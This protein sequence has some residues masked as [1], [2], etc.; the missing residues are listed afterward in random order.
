MITDGTLFTK[1]AKVYMAKKPSMT[2]RPCRRRLAMPVQE[3]P[4]SPTRKPRKQNFRG[5]RAAGRIQNF[6]AQPLSGSAITDK[7]NQGVLEKFYWDHINIHKD[8]P[9][10]EYLSKQSGFPIGQV[11]EYLKLVSLR[12][13]QRVHRLGINKI[14]TALQL[15]SETGDPQAIKLYFQLVEDWSERLRVTN[16]D[17]P[18]QVIVVGGKEI[19]F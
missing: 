1:S 12:A 10:L 9:S 2:E 3:G 8:A 16:P 6:V 17:G 5:G 11:K 7:M 19:K 14:L 15:R 18:T 4:L 13:L